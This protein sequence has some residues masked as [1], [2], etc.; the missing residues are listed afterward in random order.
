MGGVRGNFRQGA[1]E[2]EE[3]RDREWKDVLQQIHLQ[4]PMIVLY[5]SVCVTMC[6]EMKK[7]QQGKVPAA[8]LPRSTASL[9]RSTFRSGS[10]VLGPE[11]MSKFGM[12]RSAS[13][14]RDPKKFSHSGRF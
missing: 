11:G 3:R 7:Y 12:N 4:I 9:G 5:F 13:L 2:W 1:R 10:V 14:N 8:A 6:A